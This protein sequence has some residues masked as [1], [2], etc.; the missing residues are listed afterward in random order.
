MYAQVAQYLQDNQIFLPMVLKSRSMVFE[1][2]ARMSIIYKKVIIG[3]IVEVY[4][5]C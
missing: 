5:R 2:F 1:F 3:I 4:E